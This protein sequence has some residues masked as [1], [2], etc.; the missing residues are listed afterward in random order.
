MLCP[1][2]ASMQ[3]YSGWMRDAGFERVEAEEITRHVR[4]T[5]ARCATIAR[6]TEIRALLSAADERTRR[7][8]EAFALMRQAYDEG[9]MAYGMF[10]ARKV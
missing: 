9:A 10:T 6:R 4:E 3:D 7:F 2:L 8:V 1:Q 5:W